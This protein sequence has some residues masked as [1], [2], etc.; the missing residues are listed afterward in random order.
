ML[1]TVKEKAVWYLKVDEE[2]SGV[3]VGV[4][5]DNRNIDDNARIIHKSN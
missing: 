1:G 2:Q 5:D 3:R 4:Q